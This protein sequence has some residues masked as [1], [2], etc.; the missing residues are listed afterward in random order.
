LAG[1][2]GHIGWWIVVI[3]AY[4][5]IA[6]MLPVSQVIARIYPL[7]AAALIVMSVL[8]LGCI[9]IHVDG[10]PEV[11]DGL[12]SRLPDP[13][14]GSIFP[15]L[16]ITVAC[17]AI[18]GFHAT[19]SPMMARC[20]R[21]EW[22][23][24]PIF[25]GTMIT[26]GLISLIWAAVGSY[27]FYGT[28]APGYTLIASIAE[29][30][31]NTSAPAAVNAVC[32]HWLG[33]FGGVL[34]LLGV[35]AAPITTGDTALRSSRL[36]LADFLN[37]SQRSIRNRLLITAPLMIICILLLWWQI[38]DVEGF[39]IVWVYFGWLN[40][41]LSIFTL[42]A[43]TVYLASKGKSFVITLL[44]A[45]FMTAVCVTFPLVSRESLGMDMS[46]VPFI[47]IMVSLVSFG[48]FVLWYKRQAVRRGSASIKRYFFKLH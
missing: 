48:A 8:V 47:A 24:R 29:S 6:T 44:P 35:V 9:F 7:F 1:V 40:Q 46:H 4:Y 5:F 39:A 23:G 32:V 43:L 19:Q 41:L 31:L 27:L 28:P 34:A 21:S 17:G 12:G 14:T 2:F 11:W 45:I 22:Q 38:A 15:Y 16:F 30:G 42:W 10:M 3:F 37:I 20:M 26:E 13:Q 36:I 18:S 25:Y 33:M